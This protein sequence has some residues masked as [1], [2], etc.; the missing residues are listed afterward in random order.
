MKVVLLVLRVNLPDL[1]DDLNPY[2]ATGFYLYPM[3]TSENQRFSNVS[4]GL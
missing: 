2:D 1:E 3:K 4:R